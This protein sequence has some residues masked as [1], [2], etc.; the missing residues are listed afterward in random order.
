MPW[1]SLISRER[2]SSFR[3]LQVC[4]D[5]LL[6]GSTLLKIKIRRTYFVKGE[7]PPDERLLGNSS[8]TALTLEEP[9]SNPEPTVEVMV[10]E[11]AVEAPNLPMPQPTII[12]LDD[13]PPRTRKR[14]AAGISD[15]AATTIK[16]EP[17]E[18]DNLSASPMTGTQA[19]IDGGPAKKIKLEQGAESIGDDEDK[20]LFRLKEE[21]ERQEEE[22]HVIQR[23]AEMLR[24][25]NE[26]KA[27]IAA[28]EA[29]AS[30]TPGAGGSS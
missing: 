2:E 8:K 23:M 15:L 3:K 22:L 1:L 14:S 16:A 30:A 19:A 25:R 13:T 7:Y 11:E 5:K 20:E 6:G 17:V 21:D 28:L 26:R 24:Q 12:I 10:K 4:D 29:R 9:A 27:R 18:V